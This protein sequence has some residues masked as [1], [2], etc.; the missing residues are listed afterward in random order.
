M[1]T[2]TTKYPFV[3][4]IETR[5]GGRTDN[6]D[7]AGFVDTPLGLLVVVC[8]GMGGGPGGRTA[9]LM[10][11]DTILNVLSETAEHTPRE[12]ALTF[13]I[14]KANDIIYS[15]AKE[16]PELRGMGTTV[17]AVLI[18][19]KSAVIAHAGD[20]RVY[21]LRKGSIVFR[22]S[23]HSYVADLVRQKKISEEEARNHPQSNIVTRALGI[24]PSVE[25]ELDEI[26]FL[27]GDRFLVCTD[28]IW[29]ML[30]QCDLV[31]KISQA[32]GIGEL[33]SSLTEEIDCI[34]QANGGNHDN[35]TLAVF[36]TSF[37]SAVKNN[38]KKKPIWIFIIIAVLVA[39]ACIS[40]VKFFNGEKNDKQEATIGTSTTTLDNDKPLIPETKPDGL[41]SNDI[42]QVAILP[43][44]SMENPE[45]P[46]QDSTIINGQKQE[47][48]REIRTVVNNLDN[49]KTIRDRGKRRTEEKKLGFVRYV[50]MPNVNRLEP[51]VAEEKKKD[52]REIIKLLHDRKTIS[53]DRNGKTSIEGNVHIEIIKTK[54]IE[55]Q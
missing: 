46:F 31:K 26:P 47:L 30:P 17:A 9:S 3:G 12:D 43:K 51:K 25:I 24:K 8:D 48:S 27:R 52:V 45:N 42:N 54:V 29:G 6:Q 7:N 13:A 5:Q 16:T 15:K 35:L 14:E 39:F 1:T 40:I 18:N 44:S 34:G 11:V 32:K 38:K 4:S 20:T 19:E 2:I 23:D 36:D 41:D 22:S 10:A 53:C 50:I 49:L 21:Q 37:D 28:G 33:T 55:L